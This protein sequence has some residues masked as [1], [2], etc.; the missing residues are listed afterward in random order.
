M[1][2][3]D[4]HK[5][6][7]GGGR[8]EAGGWWEIGNAQPTAVLPMAC[9]LDE[10]AP[11][12]SNLPPLCQRP[13]R[14][15]LGDK[16][17]AAEAAARGECTMYKAG[18]ATAT[19]IPCRVPMSGEVA[20]FLC[21][22]CSSARCCRRRASMYCRTIHS[23][24]S[25]FIVM[26]CYRR[27][28]IAPRACTAKTAGNRADHAQACHAARPRPPPPPWGTMRAAGQHRLAKLPVILETGDTCLDT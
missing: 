3:V 21:V 17:G 12:L 19:A 28:R 24:A 11:N 14:G 5:R 10:L 9:M 1:A 25:F 22:P 6:G 2:R 15:T 4:F 23:I 26:T 27:R 20:D 8:A 18:T 13:G 7:G 16:A